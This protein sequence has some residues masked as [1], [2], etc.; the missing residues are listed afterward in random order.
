M[1]FVNLF[2]R[3]SPAAVPN[4]ALLAVFFC[5]ISLGCAFIPEQEQLVSAK[6]NAL[7]TR[8]NGS[9]TETALAYSDVGITTQR[10]ELSPDSIAILDWNIHKGKDKGW[11]SDF[12]RFSMK[13]DILLLQEAPLNDELQ[14]LL[15]QKQLYWN[16]NSA[17]RYRGV[18]TGVLVASTIEPLGS[19]GMRYTEPLI[20]L[21][22]TILINRYAIAGA[23]DELLVAT[24]HGIN[25]T[26]GIGAYKAQFQALADVLQQHK[27]PLILA[28]DF[29]NW[30][31]KRTAVVDFLVDDLSLSALPFENEGRTTFFGDPVDHFLYR[32][33]EP[34]AHMVH[35]VTSSDHNP[36]SVTFRLV[37]RLDTTQN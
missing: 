12:L 18:E 29:N 25:I 31:D 30:S 5:C 4:S 14:Y 37:Q 13:K 16:L 33:M 27:G 1:R 24:V 20:G 28:G 2:N 19:C 15:Q 35:P 11:E 32:G 6:V 26:L 10:A 21:P 3:L 36:I 22:K 23:K 7:L 34:V 8:S 17:F 9:C